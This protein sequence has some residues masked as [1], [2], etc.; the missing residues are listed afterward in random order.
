[1]DK[2]DLKNKAISLREKG[3]SYS[4]IQEK[5]G[6]L[7]KSTL[8]NWLG[9][10]PLS[11]E[12]IERLE[13]KSLVRGRA[14]RLKG[15]QTNQIMAKKRIEE[16]YETAEKEFL[17]LSQNRLF[18]IG[19]ALYWAEGNQKT[20]RFQFTNS[21]PD[22]IKI[23]MRWLKDI[24]NVK[25]SEIKYRLFI[26]D[27]YSNEKCEEFW[28]DIV[29]EPLSSF[30]KTIYKPNSHITKKN[31]NYKGCLKVDVKGSDL[32]WKVQKWQEMLNNL[33]SW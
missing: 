33:P 22:M 31:P 29:G 4:E 21:N 19:I 13:R 9:S 10:I 5:L 8:S 16:I 32:Y 20:K 30:L 1:M 24:C 7:S 28:S 23:M 18:L 25:S 17:Q 3:C 12:Q 15:A 14:G 6:G 11:R 27:V 2:V 26:H